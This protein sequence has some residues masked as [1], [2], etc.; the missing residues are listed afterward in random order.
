MVDNPKNETLNP[1][2]YALDTRSTPNHRWIAA[3]SRAQLTLTLTFTATP[4]LILTLTVR[5]RRPKDQV[6]D[7]MK[8]NREESIYEPGESFP[9]GGDSTIIDLISET[10]Q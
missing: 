7:T 3:A 5:L 1:K 9:E 2:P 6:E 8:G 4:T 10:V